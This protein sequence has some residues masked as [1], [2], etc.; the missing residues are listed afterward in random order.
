MSLILSGTDGLS[1][2]DGSAATPAIRGTDANTGMF[3]PA[4]DTIAFSEGGVE[5][6]RIDSA[7]NLGIGT[8]SPAT[9]LNIVGAGCQYRFDTANAGGAITVANPAFS[10][11]AVSTID[12]LQH[13]FNISGSEKM[14]ILSTGNVAIGT[15]AIFDSADRVLTVNGTSNSRFEMGT[16]GAT[17][18][19]LYTGGTELNLY[20]AGAIPLNLGTNYSTRVTIDTSGNVGVNNTSPAVIASTT[21][22]A[23]KA[24]VSGD[25]MFVAQNSNGLTTAKFGF[26]FTGSIDQPV[27]GSQTNHPFVFLTN[28]TER[29]RVDT[30]GNLLVGTTTFN[31]ARINT[32]STTACGISMAGPVTVNNGASRNVSC[33]SNAGLVLISNDNTGSGALFYVSYLSGTCV[34]LADPSSLYANSVTAGKISLTKS[35][36]SL[37]VTLTNNGGSNQNFTVAPVFAGS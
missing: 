23:I 32:N 22:V 3:F 9:K 30:S 7:G 33:P 16:G 5:S 21:Q 10:A 6:M 2:V 37:T 28:N 27:I 35:A 11:Y 15:T 12:A 36:N 20:S 19:G 25:S 26:Q 14:R 18:G 34:L 29:M 17:R 13:V 4:A 24:N 8:A 31:T 1:D